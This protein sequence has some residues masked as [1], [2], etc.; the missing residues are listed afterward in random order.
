MNLLLF[1]IGKARRDAVGLALRLDE[2]R[3]L[4][5]DI[6]HVLRWIEVDAEEMGKCFAS[7]PAAELLIIGRTEEAM[8]RIPQRLRETEVPVNRAYELMSGRRADLLF[9]IRRMD[10]AVAIDLVAKSGVDSIANDVEWPLLVESLG[11][12]VG[13]VEAHGLSYRTLDEFGAEA[14]SYDSDA[15]QWIRRIEMAGEMARTMRPFLKGRS[16][17]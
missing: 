9:A 2:T 1:F 12:R 13:Y 11:Y 10:R 5:S 4:Y 7:Q 6:D 8:Q 16:G 14:D 3:V 15:L 17:E